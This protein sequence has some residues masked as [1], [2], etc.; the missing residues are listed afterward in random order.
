MLVL[1]WRVLSD[2]QSWAYYGMGPLIAAALLDT[3]EANRLPGWTALAAVGEFGIRD[4]HQAWAG[5][6][7]IV[8]FVVVVGLVVRRTRTADDLAEAP[9]SP[10]TSVPRVLAD[11]M[12]ANQN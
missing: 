10:E 8:W 5:W 3:V 6:A 1:G 4:L 2:P 9:G 12:V 11:N 7:Q